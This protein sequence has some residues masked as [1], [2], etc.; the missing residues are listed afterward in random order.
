MNQTV[1][2]EAR[3]KEKTLRR[4][5]RSRILERDITCRLHSGDWPIDEDALA[6]AHITPMAEFRAKLGAMAGTIHSYRPDNL[7]LLCDV[8]HAVQESFDRQSSQ[9][10]RAWFRD[11]VAE[12]YADKSIH[13]IP[14]FRKQYNRIQALFVDLKAE[15]GWATVD[16]LVQREGI[17][18]DS[19]APQG[20]TFADIHSG[21]LPPNTAYESPLLTDLCSIIEGVGGRVLRKGR[22]S[23][24][25][26]WYEAQ[27]PGQYL[28]NE[29]NAPA[30]I[31]QRPVE[32]SLIGK[33]KRAFAK[34]EHPAVL[35]QLKVNDVLYLLHA[36]RQ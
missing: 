7:L 19:D 35:R 31:F 8:C 33:I 30:V 3:R 34:T 2:K 23:D 24:F 22:A 14:E 20:P 27:G 26:S 10:L 6:V 1:S 15:R 28:F 16:E 36:H 11:V 18:P 13:E 32:E 12:E 9:P 21:D 5:M 29:H 25:I 4:D 17:L